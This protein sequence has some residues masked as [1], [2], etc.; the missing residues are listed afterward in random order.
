MIGQK[1]IKILQTLDPTAFRRLGDAIASPYF[2][3]SPLLLKLYALL[4][5]E[6]PEFDSTRLS[7][8]LGLVKPPIR[9]NATPQQGVFTCSTLRER[10][11]KTT[12]RGVGPGMEEMAGED[13]ARR[14]ITLCCR[15]K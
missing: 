15:Y 11:V 7:A 8:A 12:R 10:R 5:K 1:L 6:Y 13:R 3:Y 14:K 2:T 9:P 4:K